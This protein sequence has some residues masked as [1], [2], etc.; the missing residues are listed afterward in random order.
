M[1]IRDSPKPEAEPAAEPALQEYPDTRDDD[2]EFDYTEEIEFDDDL[3]DFLVEDLS[4]I[5]I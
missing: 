5:Q 3:S 4:L 2:E 1:C